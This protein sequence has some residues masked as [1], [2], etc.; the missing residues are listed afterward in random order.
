MIATLIEH[1][2]QA[3]VLHVPVPRCSRLYLL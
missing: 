2:G 3:S 1:L